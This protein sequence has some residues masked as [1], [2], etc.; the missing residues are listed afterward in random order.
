MRGSN[1]VDLHVRAKFFNDCINQTGI[2]QRFVPLDIEH[3][4]K[5]FRAA[6]DFR[7]PISPATMSRGGQSDL[8]A[9]LESGLGDA[10]I[11]GGNDQPV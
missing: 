5:S 4:R 6:C 11:V 2:E 1:D 8:G 10:H 3:E 7:H 9:P